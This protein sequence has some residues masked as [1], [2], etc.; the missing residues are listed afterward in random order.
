MSKNYYRIY[1]KK[2]SKRQEKI[3]RSL[4]VAL[5]ELNAR[6]LNNDAS[7]KVRRAAWTPVH[8]PDTP[9]QSNQPIAVDPPKEMYELDIPKELTEPYGT[10]NERALI[11]I[12]KDKIDIL[13]TDASI[14]TEKCGEIVADVVSK[15]Y[16]KATG[17]RLDRSQIA[18]RPYAHLSG[19]LCE[20]CLE[21]IDS[22]PYRCRVCGRCFCY[23]HRAPETHGCAADQ[24]TTTETIVTTP[25]ES[26]K[27]PTQIKPK[28]II[29]R[30]P[31]G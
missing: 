11:S 16:E 13:L 24:K 27:A 30:V 17:K 10:S 9:A 18:V 3:N 8:K 19:S 31:C 28:L 14:P 7:Q 26:A 6:R 22:Q 20:H 1:L 21:S 29:Q 4:L 15:M 12:D 2:T 25:A 23:L 5:N